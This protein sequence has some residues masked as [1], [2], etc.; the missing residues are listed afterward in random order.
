MSRENVEVAKNVELALRLYDAFNRRDLE[1]FLTLMHEDAE[2]GS[3]LVAVE[4]EYRGHDGVR[5]WW[6]SFLGVIPDYV[7]HPVAVRDFG[8]VTV[9]E[10]RGEGHRGGE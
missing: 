3:R 8:D 2:A 7:A 10:L 6:S 1:A 9:A 5:R 4:G